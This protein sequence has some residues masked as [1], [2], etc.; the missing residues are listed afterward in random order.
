MF[1][2]GS[3]PLGQRLA[4]VRYSF[5]IC[6]TEGRSQDKEGC[7]PWEATQTA[8][9][10]PNGVN[11]R[12]RK[13][14]KSEWKPGV[15]QGGQGGQWEDL[16]PD[17]SDLGARAF[18]RTERS[19]VCHRLRS[20]GSSAGPQGSS[21]AD[22]RIGGPPPTLNMVNKSPGVQWKDLPSSEPGPGYV[23]QGSHFFC[24]FPVF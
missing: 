13:A 2:A 24:E 6:R 11:G 15:T 8:P 20:W 9:A 7:I 12:L 19:A 22:P 10:G 5:N 21:S 14:A 17:L 1:T 18:P 3:Q 16:H 4:Q 23:T